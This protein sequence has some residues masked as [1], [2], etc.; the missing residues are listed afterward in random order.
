MQGSKPL[1]QHDFTLIQNTVSD[2]FSFLYTIDISTLNMDQKKD[3]QQALSAA[4]LALVRLEN[5]RFEALSQELSKTLSS[6]RS[7]IVDINSQLGALQ[8]TVKKLEMLARAAKVFQ[9]LAGLLA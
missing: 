1:T 6:L 5:A 2:A 3:H 7:A 9:T 8:G 4:H